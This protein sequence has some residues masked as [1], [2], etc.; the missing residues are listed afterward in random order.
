[1]VF[2]D[3]DVS[4]VE[5]LKDLV[6]KS[7]ALSE[8]TNRV[9]R[10]MRK[11][12]QWGSIFQLLWWTVIITVSGATYYLYL[13]PYVGRI[14]QIYEQAQSGT[15]QVQSWNSQLQNFFKNIATKIP[16]SNNTSSSTQ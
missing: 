2:M 10:K 11:A 14:E 12:Q 4:G 13:Q 5:E 6:R 9:V 8:D 1:M 15:H 7:V 16:A 3:D